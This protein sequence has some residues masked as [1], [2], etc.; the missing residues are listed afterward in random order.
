MLKMK[1]CLLKLIMCIG[2]T[3]FYILAPIIICIPLEFIDYYMHRNV[4]TVS[5]LIIISILLSVIQYRYTSIINNVL[6]INN[7]D[8]TIH[9]RGI[10]IDKLYKITDNTSIDDTTQIL[11]NNLPKEIQTLCTYIKKHKIS[12]F[13]TKTHHFFYEE[14]LEVLK[15]DPDLKF[16]YSPEDIKAIENLQ[17][18][19][20]PYSIKSKDNNCI[21]TFR[22]LEKNKEITERVFVFPYK[23]LKTATTDELNKIFIKRDEY[24]VTVNITYQN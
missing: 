19:D 8:K 3:K 17:L 4:C 23:K 22:L 12:T 24:I 18:Q 20:E 13:Q 15:A 2:E 14:L 21:V 10:R 6:K 7:K 11:K 1:Y 9:M 5:I 16:E